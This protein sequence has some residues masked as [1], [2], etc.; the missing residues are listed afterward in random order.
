MTLGDCRNRERAKE[1][2]RLRTLGSYAMY[3]D[4]NEQYVEEMMGVSQFSRIHN[5]LKRNKGHSSTR[6]PQSYSQT[7]A[8]PLDNPWTRHH[9]LF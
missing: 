8:N 1:R 7:P 6:S 4:A 5:W 3:R 2:L 9:Q